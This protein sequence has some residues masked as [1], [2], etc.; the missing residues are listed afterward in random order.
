MDNELKQN[1]VRLFS[2]F[3]LLVSVLVASFIPFSF[4][5][6]NARYIGK[7]ELGFAILFSGISYISIIISE[8]GQMKLN[9]AKVSSV[10]TY[11]TAGYVR[12]KV[13]TGI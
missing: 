10:P 12:V 2:K 8:W 13:D 1:E 9:D 4:W 11:S 6:V 3:V 5:A 7:Y